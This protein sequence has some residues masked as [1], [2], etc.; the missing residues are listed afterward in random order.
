MKEGYETIF[1]HVGQIYVAHNPTVISTVLG[2]CVAVCLFDKRELIAG[3]NHYL[4]PLWNNNGLKTPRFGNV[5][6]PKLINEMLDGGS[7]IKNL[8]AKLFGGANLNA[9]ND[10]M[11]IGKRNIMVAKE[12]LKEYRIPILAEDT[13]GQFGRKIS[14]TSDTGKVMMN[15]ATTKPQ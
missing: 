8:Q 14:M 7:E 2:S 9:I 13:A 4:L 5:S 11:M 12:I 3:M 6:I 15:Y 10:S 1:I